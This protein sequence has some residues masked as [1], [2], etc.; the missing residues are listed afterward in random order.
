MGLGA[1]LGGL[2]CLPTQLVVGCTSLSP[3]GVLTVTPAGG[4]GLGGGVVVFDALLP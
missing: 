4:R 1:V 3:S 2:G